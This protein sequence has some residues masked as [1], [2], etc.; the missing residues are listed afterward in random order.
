M[1]ALAD[2]LPVEAYAW[3]VRSALKKARRF[4]R[5]LALKVRPRC[6]R[7]PWGLSV[8]WLPSPWAK[9]YQFSIVPTSILPDGRP[10]A[11]QSTS[12]VSITRSPWWSRA[13]GFHGQVAA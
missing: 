1:A 2:E 11:D 8:A 9:A 7:T 13:R 5:V 4:G 3:H 12:A 10:T 6:G